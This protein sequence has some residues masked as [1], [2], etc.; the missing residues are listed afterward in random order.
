MF[1]CGVILYALFAKDLKASLLHD[2]PQRSENFGEQIAVTNSQR[3]FEVWSIYSYIFLFDRRTTLGSLRELV[4]ASA[5]S[6]SAH[7]AS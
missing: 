1:S 2:L 3:V 7:M 5:L 4:L 6:M